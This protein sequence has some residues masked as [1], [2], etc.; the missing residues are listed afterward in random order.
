VIKLRYNEY[1]DYYVIVGKFFKRKRAE[2]SLSIQDVADILG[3]SKGWYGDAERGRNA[4]TLED[5]MKICDI[6]HTDLGELD[7][8]IRASLDNKKDT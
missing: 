6:Y 4:L 2:T 3:R 5:C 7:K 8:F 1:N